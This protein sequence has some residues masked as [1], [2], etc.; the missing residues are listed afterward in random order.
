MP[1]MLAL[2]Q[3]GISREDAYRI[4]QR[5]AMKVWEERSGGTGSLTLRSAIENDPQATEKLDKDVLDAIFS[6]DAYTKHIQS[7]ISRTLA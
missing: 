6:Y 1:V 5:S 7:I 4:V 2:T 3:A